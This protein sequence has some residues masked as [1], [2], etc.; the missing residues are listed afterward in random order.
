MVSKQPGFELSPQAYSFEQENVPMDEV[1]A[2]L[3]Y[4]LAPD[5]PY[6]FAEALT[7]LGMFK[8]MPMQANMIRPGSDIPFSQTGNPNYKRP[9]AMYQ[10]NRQYFDNPLFKR[11]GDNIGAAG[12]FYGGSITPQ[13]VAASMKGMGGFQNVRGNARGQLRTLLG[14]LAQFFLGPRLRDEEGEGRFTPGGKELYGAPMPIGT[15]R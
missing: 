12:S 4:T 13:S 9:Q 11:F 6:N 3:P 1:G 10:F 14:P 5:D 7:S 15:R 2:G 8:R